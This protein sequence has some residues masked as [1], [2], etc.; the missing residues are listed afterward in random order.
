M[1]KKI[2]LWFEGLQEWSLTRI[3]HKIK[4]ILKPKGLNAEIQWE[5][6]QKLENQ[7]KLKKN[8]IL[9]IKLMKMRFKQRGKKENLWK[10][11]F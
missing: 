2:K 11:F 10:I 4:K 5:T 7:N 6:T 8:V 3:N 9:I 1:L